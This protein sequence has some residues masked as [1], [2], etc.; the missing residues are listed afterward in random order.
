VRRAYLAPP[1]LRALLAQPG[2]KVKLAQLVLLV[3]LGWPALKDRRELLVLRVLPGRRVQAVP[4]GRAD[5]RVLMDRPDLQGL[6]VQPVLPVLPAHRELLA[7]KALRVLPVPLV[8]VFAF[9]VITR[10]G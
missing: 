1:A 2:H 6:L 9:A 10:L 5:L 8:S 3:L 4:K 7:L